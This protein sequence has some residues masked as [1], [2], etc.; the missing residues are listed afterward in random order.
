MNECNEDDATPEGSIA[1]LREDLTDVAESFKAEAQRNQSDREEGEPVEPPQ[2][3]VARIPADKQDPFNPQAVLL[4]SHEEGSEQRT[5]PRRSEQ[6]GPGIPPI[7]SDSITI[8]A[9]VLEAGGAYTIECSIRN[10]GGLPAR[11]VDVELY[12]EHYV[13]DAR[14]DT[15][16]GTIELTRNDRLRGGHPGYQVSGVTT[17]APDSK[18]SAVAHM[19][20]SGPPFDKVVNY[21]AIISV[22][23]DRTF[24][25]VVNGKPDTFLNGDP[26]PADQDDF[27]LE[28]WE[29]SLAPSRAFGSVKGDG[30]SFFED[31]AAYD[32]IHLA[33]VSG[34][35]VESPSSPPNPEN[36]YLT[37]TVESQETRKV[38]KQSTSIPG[39][40]GATLS[41][42]YSPAWDEYPDERD[43]ISEVDDGEYPGIAPDD[44]PG[45]GRAVTVFY[46]RA[47]SLAT[48]E[49]PD[50][51]SALDHT[52]SRFMGRSESPRKF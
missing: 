14:L 12:V 26:I 41:F 39:G 10:I 5:L 50:D 34:R 21:E 42:T 6:V 18:L 15:Q 2:D 48:S 47:Y 17:M 52:T 38:D 32:G 30:T 13:P 16:G 31:P 36:Q 45:L 23:D 37:N 11:K 29:T 20:D 44:G 28:L 46:V 1:D 35:F 49:M 22:G 33:S 4:V 25:G 24:T 9:D 19:D 27:T 8:G 40:D 43:A 3:P 7:R 51:W